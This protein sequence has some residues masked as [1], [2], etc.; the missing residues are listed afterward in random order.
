MIDWDA[1]VIGPTVGVFGQPVTYI[2]GAGSPVF[3]EGPFDITAVFDEG[4]SPA[5]QFSDPSVSTSQPRLGI[6]LSE[7]PDG[8]E[9]ETAQGDTFL[10]QRTGKTYIVKLGMADGYGGARLDANL[11]P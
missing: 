8:Y 9:A 2:P 1:L 11:A 10:V 4:Y 3:D 5:D 7:F 6:R